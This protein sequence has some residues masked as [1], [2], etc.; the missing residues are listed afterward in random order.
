M[1]ILYSCVERFDPSSGETWQNYIKWSGLTQLREVVSL[2]G[3]LC[4][5]IFQ[6]LTDEDWKYN[7]QED[8]KT[9]LFSSLDHVLKRVAGNERVNI[10]ALM[11]NPP[12]EDVASF[13]D[14]R[15]AFR[16]FDLIEVQGTISALVN[17]GGFDTV[18]SNAE[19]S[20]F[21]LI[22]EHQRAFHIQQGL[23]ERYPDEPH[24]ECDVWAIWQMALID[25]LQ[26]MRQDS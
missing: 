23:R 20:E 25:E 14:S 9:H 13:A 16:G 26:G 4:P 1:P 12:A 8:F 7:V 17:C 15:F 11:E 10:L 5:S 19:L 22:T 18:F 6:E 3:I 24:A 2:D 21:G